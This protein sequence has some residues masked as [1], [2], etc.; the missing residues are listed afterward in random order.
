MKELQVPEFKSYEE[1][2]SFWDNID[3]AD[4]MPDNEDWFRFDTP[5]KRAI[6]VSVLPEIATEL[7]KRAHVQGVSI[8]T[9][10]NVFLIERIQHTESGPERSGLHT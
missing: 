9:L 4:F 1:E 2:A 7:I 8:E 6:R 5:D 3:T 10:V